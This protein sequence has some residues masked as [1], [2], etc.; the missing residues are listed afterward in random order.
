MDQNDRQLIDGLFRKLGDAERQ[1]PPRDADADD[2]IR[3]HLQRQPAAPY[4]MAQAVLVQEQ[5]LN[6]LNAR[7]QELE[8]E[9]ARRPRQATSGGF[10]GG[11]FGAKPHQPAAPAHPPRAGSVPVSGGLWNRGA[12][13]AHVSSP[14]TPY[15]SHHS[16]SASYPS[17]P[18]GYGG[19]SGFMSGAL[20][21]AMG[22]A[23]GV[24][25]GN[26]LAGMFSGN[27]A[28][29]AQGTPAE[30]PADADTAANQ[31]TPDTGGGFAPDPA[32]FGPDPGA[33][34]GGDFGGEEEI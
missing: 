7:V 10:L 30:P 13:Q 3:Q 23:G 12:P 25:L 9:L 14:H 15:P 24:L 31:G 19:R 33:D 5:A 17:Q 1:G 16:P 34:F 2:L 22:V 11:L 20:Q 26:A 18:Y 32:D 21:T 29:A 6:A 8:A 27:D 28:Q 4:Y